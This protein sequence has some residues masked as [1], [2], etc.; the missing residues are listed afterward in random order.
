[1]DQINLCYKDI[2]C[3]QLGQ[4]NNYKEN[5]SINDNILPGHGRVKPAIQYDME[6]RIG[7]YCSEIPHA[8]EMEALM[9]RGF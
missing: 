1:M 3:I 8:A 9:R 2:I 4:K 6:Y 5:E 7:K